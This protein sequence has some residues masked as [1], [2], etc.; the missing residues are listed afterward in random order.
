MEPRLGIVGRAFQ[1]FKQSSGLVLVRNARLSV[2]VPGAISHGSQIEQACI[3]GAD[4]LTELAG[5]ERP[6]YPGP[7][8]PE[9]RVPE[10]RHIA[11]ALSVLQGCLPERGQRRWDG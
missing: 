1:R 7:C 8:R 4:H 6:P 3:A 2:E 11:M 10:A 5:K 9:E